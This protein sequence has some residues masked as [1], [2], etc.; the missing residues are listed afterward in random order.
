MAATEQGV[1][2]FFN[3]QKGWGFVKRQHG[4]DI[5]C[6]FSAIV[7]EGYKS[8]RAGDMVEF[9]VV[10]GEKGPQASQVKVIEGE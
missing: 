3:N 4:P 2:I 8:L 7:A 5:F 1:V 6:H 10:R 9:E